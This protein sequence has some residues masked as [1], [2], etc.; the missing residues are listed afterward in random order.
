[1]VHTVIYI[2]DTKATEG[3]CMDHTVW[4][5]QYGKVGRGFLMVIWSEFR[6]GQYRDDDHNQDAHFKRLTVIE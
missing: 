2:L 5:I 6:M 1:M 4:T 3:Q